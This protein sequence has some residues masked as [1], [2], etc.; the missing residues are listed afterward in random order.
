[1][2][3]DNRS[4]KATVRRKQKARDQG[5]VARSRDLAS[6][7]GVLTV[8]LALAWQPHIWV[9]RW[10]S[11]FERLLTMGGQS[12][13]GTGQQIF[14]SSALAMAQWSGPILLL[15]FCISIG[16]FALQGGF[17]FATEA[18][19]FNPGRLNPAANVGQIFSDAWA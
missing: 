2:A 11:L 16:A 8:T 3:A 14:T 13:P 7:L 19:K 5:Q 15:A 17:V 9:S 12:D 4:E 10:H 18:L 6:A 1:M